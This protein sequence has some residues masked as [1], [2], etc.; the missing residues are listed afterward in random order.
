MMEVCDGVDN[1]CNG[2][3]DEGFANLGTVCQA[4][5][6]ACLRYLARSPATPRTTAPRVPRSRARRS[7]SCATTSTTI[8][9]AR[10]DETFPT[11]GTLRAALGLGVC[12]RATARSSAARTTPPRPA[13]SPPARRRVRRSATTSTTT[14]TASSTIHSAMRAARTARPRR[15]AARAATTARRSSASRTPR[16]S[17]WSSPRKPQCAMQCTAGYFDLDASTLDGCEF[18]LD[19]TAIYVSGTSAAAIDDATCGLGPTGTGAG[20]HPCKTITF[21]LSRAATTSRANV[22]VANATYN[23]AVV[24]ANGKNL[25]GGYTATFSRDLANTST[26]IQGVSSMGAHD[27]TVTATNISSPTVFEGFVVRGSDNAKVGGN[28]YAIYVANGNAGLAIRSNQI[29][30]GRGGPGSARLAGHE[31]HDRHDRRRVHVRGLRRVPGD[32]LRPVSREQQPAA[33]TAAACWTCGGTSV[34]GGNGGGNNCTPNDDT[35]ASTTTSPATAGMAGGGAG[36]GTGGAPGTSGY[37]GQEGATG[38]PQ[39]SNTCFAQAAAS[40]N[41]LP[42][43]G[44]DGVAGGIGA[45]AAGV[46]GCSAAGGGVVGGQW[47]AGGGTIGSSVHTAAVAAVAVPVVARS[48]RAAR[49]ATATRRSAVT[50]AAAAAVGARRD[51]RPRRQRRWCRVRHLRDERRRTDDRLELDRARRRWQRWRG[52]HRRRRRARWSRWLGRP[53]RRAVLHRQ[54]RQR[55]RRRQR[56]RGL[57][58]WRRVRRWHVRHL[59]LRR[60]RADVLRVLEH[61][62]RGHRGPRRSQ[63]IFRRRAEAATAWPASSRRARACDDPPPTQALAHLRR[64][65]DGVRRVEQRRAGCGTGGRPR[66]SARPA[67]PRI[68]VSRAARASPAPAARS[69]RTVVTLDVRRAGSAASRKWTARCSRCASRRATTSARRARTT[70][71]APVARASP[72]VATTRACPA[73]AVRSR[74]RRA[75]RAGRIRRTRTRAR[76]ASRTRSRARARPRRATARSARARTPTRTACARASRPATRRRAAGSAAA[77]QHLAWQEVCDGVDNNC[78]GLVDEN[79]DNQPCANSVSGIGSCPGVTL[80]TGLG[81]LICQARTPMAEA[82]NGLDDDCDGMVDEGF[83]N[84]GTV[85]SVGVGGCQRFGVVR[86]DA[87]HTGTECS[88]TAAAPIAELCNNVDD[89]CDGKIDETFPTLGQTCT[90]GVGQCARQGRPC[91]TASGSR[92]PSP[93]ARRAP[94]SAMG[95]TTTATARSTRA[96]RTR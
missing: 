64:R 14:A 69:A 58:R 49:P 61:G 76:S 44:A 96:S 48:A 93:P 75:T 72:P 19:A 67:R 35:Q 23:E 36:G 3:I 33:R 20:N 78:D 52:R 11:L 56:R 73:A 24:L 18:F 1:N 2:V 74:A 92:A 94:R 39:F 12:A 70:R 55:R 30:A 86:C 31:R 27:T 79:T 62:L 90:V 43:Y 42:V 9:T 88:A 21:G 32:R 28:S 59:H 17:A 71:P 4:G 37:D 81:G 47:V 83:A 10:L 34:A 60:R 7:P 8:A 50:A 87:A 63:R 65:D 45:N 6:G 38:Q 57:R 22:L 80:C 51:R 15:T 25:L 66:S 82:C 84:L 91:A 85:C 89:D 16:A 95:S 5:V 29:F 40:G 77:R 41:L 54:G 68:S 53:D 46:A 26:V 13:R